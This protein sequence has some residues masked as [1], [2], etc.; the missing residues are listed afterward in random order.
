[1]LM[2]K[3]FK[4]GDTVINDKKEKGIIFLSFFIT[5]NGTIN[6]PLND[7]DNITEGL[8]V[9]SEDFKRILNFSNFKNTEN[10]QADEPIYKRGFRRSKILLLEKDMN[11]ILQ[12]D[13]AKKFSSNL[14]NFLNHF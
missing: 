7:K 11:I 8:W 13:T 6:S 10:H 12:K 4:L 2:G 5:N 14:M 9:C 3:E 1:M